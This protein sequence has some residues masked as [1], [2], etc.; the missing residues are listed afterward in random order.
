MHPRLDL[1]WLFPITYA[2]HLV[3]EYGAAGGFSA[4]ARDTLG[5]ALSTAEF[6]AWN[7]LGFGLLCIGAAMVW[8]RSR[9]RWIEIAM[10]M[11][12]LGNAAAH[13]AASAVTWTYSPGLVTGALVWLPLGAWR[14]RTAYRISG[15]RGRT[16]GVLVG[17]GA[18]LV[19]LVVMAWFQP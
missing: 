4:W 13:V 9:Y 3:E 12:V 5:V 8:R 6:L 10:A 7:T 14:L 2:I 16:A 15:S 18:V 11:A 17:T 19:P 1:V